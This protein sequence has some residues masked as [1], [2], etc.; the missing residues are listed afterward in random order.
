MRSLRSIG[1]ADGAREAMCA[2]GWNERQ[3]EAVR[4][5]VRFDQ[6]AEREERR[7]AASRH[8]R[9]TRPSDKTRQGRKSALRLRRTSTHSPPTRGGGDEGGIAGQ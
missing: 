8:E 9:S 1:S 3:R 6:R 5:F 2:V 7:A 4:G